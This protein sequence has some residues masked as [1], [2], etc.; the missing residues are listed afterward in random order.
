MQ[1]FFD[2]YAAGV[3]PDDPRLSPLAAAD[4]SGLA[5]ATVIT[6]A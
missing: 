1:Y 2:C 6:A 5:A 3:D 4:L